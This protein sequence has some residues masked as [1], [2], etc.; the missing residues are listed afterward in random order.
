MLD[1]DQY[2]TGRAAAQLCSGPGSAA[3]PACS[4]A[5]LASQRYR[6]LLVHRGPNETVPVPQ[7]I[8]GATVGP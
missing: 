4:T 5:D 8:V 7:R 6:G 2:G 1:P 3:D